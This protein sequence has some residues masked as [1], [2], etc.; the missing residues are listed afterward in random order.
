MRN[1]IELGQANRA[2]G[3]RVRREL[4]Q[5]RELETGFDLRGLVWQDAATE[6]ITSARNRR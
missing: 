2:L 4:R 5:R 1:L 6:R 3:Q